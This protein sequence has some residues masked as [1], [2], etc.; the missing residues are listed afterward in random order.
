MRI[1]VCSVVFFFVG[2]FGTSSHCQEINTHHYLDALASNEGGRRI[3]SNAGT[4]PQSQN[5][6]QAIVLDKKAMNSGEKSIPPNTFFCRE[7]IWWNRC[8]KR[9]EAIQRSDA[10]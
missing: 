5:E 3:D 6:N 7:G 4:Q 2:F 10:W 8:R 1:F 9:I